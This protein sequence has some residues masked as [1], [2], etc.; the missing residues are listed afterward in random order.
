LPGEIEEKVTQREWEEK[1]LKQKEKNKEKTYT[2]IPTK[3]LS[4]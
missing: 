3:S 1:E 2:H 4:S